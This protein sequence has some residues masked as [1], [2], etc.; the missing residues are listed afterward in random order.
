MRVAKGT[1]QRADWSAASSDCFIPFL[2]LG[3]ELK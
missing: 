2:T 1:S 3:L